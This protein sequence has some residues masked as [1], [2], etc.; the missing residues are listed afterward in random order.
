MTRMIPNLLTIFNLISGT[1][2]ILLFIKGYP[3]LSLLFFVFCLLFD[4]ADGLTAR[5]LKATSEIGKQLDSFS[6]LVSFGVFPAIA[7]HEVLH[8][9]L[10]THGSISYPAYIFAY[11]V[12]IIP[13]AGSIRLAYFNTE[14]QN[15]V[16]FKGLPIPAAAIGL[17]SLVFTTK[18]LSEFSIMFNMQQFITN[19]FTISGVIIL[20]SIMMVTKIPMLS[21]KFGALN[22]IENKHRIIFLAIITGG[23]LW[24]KLWALPFLIPFYILYSLLFIRRAN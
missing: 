10:I 4:F 15:S 24:F 5:L 13:A 9:A 23:I 2:A 7:V 1:T 16:Y 14:D 20:M 3:E 18:Y 11:F 19:P 22:W 12:V 8:Q 6:D 17:L 21:F